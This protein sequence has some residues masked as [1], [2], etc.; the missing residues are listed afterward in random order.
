MK[1]DQALLK[2]SLAAN[3]IKGL[4][5]ASSSQLSRTFGLT[6]EQAKSL[7]KFHGVKDDG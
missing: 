6:T 3:K 7:L 4:D 2:L 1:K 5:S